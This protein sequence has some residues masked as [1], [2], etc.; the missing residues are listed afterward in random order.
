MPEDDEQDLLDESSIGLRAELRPGGRLNQRE[1]PVEEADY[2]R[3]RRL[4]FYSVLAGLCPLLPVP[5]LDDWALERIQRRMVRELGESRD[6][7]LTDAEV[8]LLAGEG[9]KRVWPGFVKGTA[10]AVSSGA[11]RVL[12]KVFRTAFY[13]LL[14]RDGVHRAVE[15]F[16][17]GY[18]FL[19]ASRLPHALRPAGR[20]PERVR[21][22]RA[23]VLETMRE[24]D[25]KPIHRAMG[26]AF[27][28]SF[29]LLIKA[30]GRLGGVFGRLRSGERA[31][32][33][34]ALK[35]EEELLG[36]FVDRLAASLWGNEEHFERLEKSFE[37]R[38]L[39]SRT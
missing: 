33:A 26:R 25:V 23:A 14:M 5:F 36:G 1:L 20:T 22:V 7:G 2:P 11:R 21:A 19:Y 24:E 30:A 12:R 35:E 29:D 6:L 3:F 9:E 27:R 28:R 17:Q 4:T 15:T 39:K 18:L 10:M 34:E 38:L 16:V 37:A 13:L 31:D 8:R 32:E